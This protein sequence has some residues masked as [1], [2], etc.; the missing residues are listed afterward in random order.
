MGVGSGQT[1]GPGRE[2]N[3]PSFSSRPL[4]LGS[5]REGEMS[6]RAAEQGGVWVGV[7][8][9]GFPRAR[10]FTGTMWV[11]DFWWIWRIKDQQVPKVTR[12]FP[13]LVGIAGNDL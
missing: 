11:S 2:R 13:T 8:M 12:E 4:W 3:F 10:E 7:G 9:P 5:S 6:Q 1:R